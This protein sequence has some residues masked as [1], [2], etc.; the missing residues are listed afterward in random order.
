MKLH[1]L[2]AAAFGAVAAASDG[3][4]P[5]DL[6]LRMLASI[7]QRGQA[8]LNPGASTGY[9]QLGLFGQAL[10]VVTEPGSPSQADAGLRSLLDKSLTSTIPAFANVTRDSELP[11]DR[12]SLG[13]DMIASTVKS[14]S[15]QYRPT[16]DTLKASLA[17]QPKNANG[18]LWYYDNVNN[19]T[20]YQNLSY[21]DGMY[22]YAPFITIFSQLDDSGSGP[23]AALE[24]AAQQLQILY[25][26]CRKP[27]GLLVHGY[28]AL[29]AHKWANADTGASPEVWSRALAWYSLGILNT[30]EVAGLNNG[31]RH[32]KAYNAIASLF[33]DVMSAQLQA[34]EQSKALTGVPGVWQVVDRPGDA[35]NFVEA[36]SSFMTVYTLLRGLRLNLLD[37]K[38]T[39]SHQWS[40]SSGAS[41]IASVAKNIYQSVSNEYLISYAN[42]SLSLNGTSSVASLSPQNVGYDYYVTRPTEMDSLIGTSAFALASYEVG[43]LNT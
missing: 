22:S 11:L 26:I 37:D 36:S 17:L 4:W 7:E 30:L 32:L 8:T 41:S 34:A 21:L 9:I 42:G 38:R 31:Q 10:A 1:H 24:A 35:G 2:A 27:S 40:D 28:D 20:A 6:A 33:Q 19:L 12:F 14:G 25:D 43:R 13:A 39:A 16:I 5:H 15:P 3:P 18:G 23:V 29:K